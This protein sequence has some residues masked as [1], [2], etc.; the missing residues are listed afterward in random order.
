MNLN[1]EQA[2]EFDLPLGVHQY[3]VWRGVDAHYIQSQVKQ[4]DDLF[5]ALKC[6][7]NILEGEE[8]KPLYSGGNILSQTKSLPTEVQN[9]QHLSVNLKERTN[10]M[11]VVLEL[12]KSDSSIDINN[13]EEIG[14]ASCRERV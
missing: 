13:F 5:F 9:I 1:N 10:R 4:S 11:N 6:K 3:F 2:Y 12:D 14:R 8:L 7:N